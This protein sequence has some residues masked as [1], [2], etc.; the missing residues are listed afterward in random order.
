MIGVCSLCRQHTSQVF[1]PVCKSPARLSTFVQHNG[2][3]VEARYQCS[4]YPKC[5][6]SRASRNFAKG[7]GGVVVVRHANGACPP[8]LQMLQTPP[9]RRADRRTA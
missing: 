3:Y 9:G 4:N 7:D 2:A 6:R 1:C 5:G 8:S